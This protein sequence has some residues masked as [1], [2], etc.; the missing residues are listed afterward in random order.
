MLCAT[1]VCVLCGV[2]SMVAIG[3]ARPRTKRNV[4]PATVTLLMV[5]STVLSRAVNGT[6]PAARRV[7]FLGRCSSSRASATYYVSLQAPAGGRYGE[8]Y[9]LLTLI[10]SQVLLALTSVKVYRGLAF[11]G[12]RQ[13]EDEESSLGGEQ[14]GALITHDSSFSCEATGSP[15]DGSFHADTTSSYQVCRADADPSVWDCP[16]GFLRLGPSSLRHPDDFI[17][18]LQ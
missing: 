18:F 5:G 15:H 10:L 3:E 14:G 9:K 17:M 7:D 1:H 2:H 6:W 11:R 12:S 13:F 8:G 16:I 4:G